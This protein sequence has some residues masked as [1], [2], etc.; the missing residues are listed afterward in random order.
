MRLPSGRETGLV[1]KKQNLGKLRAF[2]LCFLLPGLAGL[3]L[4]TII[5]TRYMNTLPRFPDPPNLRMNPRN[6]NGYVVYQTDQEDRFLNLVE[7]SSVAIFVLGLAT[8]LIYLQKW[9]LVRAIEA[10]DDEFIA[11]EG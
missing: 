11:E 4:S 7:Y 10:E 9:G 5:S 2:S 8:G 1:L 3:I 6:I